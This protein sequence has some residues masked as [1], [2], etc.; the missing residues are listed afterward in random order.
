MRI[1]NMS[2]S[3]N[4]KS[5]NVKITTE[6]PLVDEVMWMLMLS[7]KKR[8]D[9]RAVSIHAINLHVDNTITLPEMLTL[10]QSPTA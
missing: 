9:I 7:K 4:V 6:T 3:T 2:L 10:A 5:F 8:V 1:V